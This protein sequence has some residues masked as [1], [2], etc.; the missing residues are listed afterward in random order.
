[1]H[2]YA[3]F[4]KDWLVTLTCKVKHYLFF[5]NFGVNILFCDI[6][7]NRLLINHELL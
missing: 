4:P 6:N 1:M 2:E 3:A 5:Y 7:I